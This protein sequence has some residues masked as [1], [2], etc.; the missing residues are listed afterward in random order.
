MLL[1]GIGMVVTALAIVLGIA[2]VRRPRAGLVGLAVLG[3]VGAFAA[4]TRPTATALDALPA[5]LGAAAGAL[6]L[7]ELRRRLAGVAPT[8]ADVGDAVDPPHPLDAVERRRF[9]VRR[10][11]RSVSARSPVRSGSSSS[12][13]SQADASRAALTVPTP[14]AVRLLP[15]SAST[16]GSA[17][18]ARSSRRTTTSTGS[19]PR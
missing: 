2:S 16:S 12:R 13:R 7:L 3:A 6:T 19:T 5:V 9:L 14:P 11:S 4:L 10:A 8:P 1:V 15:R 17:A 18:S